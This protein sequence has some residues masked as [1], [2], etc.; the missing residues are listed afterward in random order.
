MKALIWIASFAV[1]VCG[2]GDAQQPCESKERDREIPTPPV[3]ELDAFPTEFQSVAIRGHAPEPRVEGNSLEGMQ[4]AYE[5]G[6]EHVEVDFQLSRDK[7]LV[8]GHDD[9][10]N[11]DCGTISERTVAELRDCTNNN[12]L[13]VAALSDLLA[14][15]FERIY[16]DMKMSDVSNQRAEEGVEAAIDAIVEADR[17]DDVFLMLYRATPAIVRMI[18]DNGVRAG[19]K[20]YPGSV[21]GARELVDR[22]ADNGFEMVCVNLDNLTPELVLYSAKR[23]VWH[24][25]WHLGG[26]RS[27]AYFR[28]AAAIGIGGLI[29]DEVRMVDEQVAP[30][31]RDV[32]ERVASEA[33]QEDASEEQQDSLVAMSAESKTEPT[34]EKIAGSD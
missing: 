34:L 19:M 18:H 31:W 3:E 11:E 23:K 28:L 6:I 7:R 21:E 16:I 9:H 24:L 30:E 5:Q 13:H 12:G 2:C 4:G 22:A 1:L 8:T 10:L 20:G 33:S 14:L 32:R 27:I 25:S 26:E 29:N 17:A 15:P